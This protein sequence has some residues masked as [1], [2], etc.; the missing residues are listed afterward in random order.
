MRPAHS[1]NAITGRI[2]ASAIEVH[3]HLGPGLLE[4]SYASCL[5]RELAERRIRYVMQ[6]PVP[7]VYKGTVLEP[8]YRV[9]LVVE[10][11]VIVEL[12]CIE[13]LLSVHDAQVLTYLRLTGCPVGLLINFNVPKLKDGIRRLLNPHRTVYLGAEIDVTG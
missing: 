10:Q 12:K 13:R 4:S 1:L 5:H 6:Q 7:L 9:D 2:V 11:M 3:R 8:A